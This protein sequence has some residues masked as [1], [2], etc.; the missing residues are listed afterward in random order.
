MSKKSKRKTEMYTSSRKNGVT[1][2]VVE[3]SSGETR[4]T[5]ISTLYP[6]TKLF[7]Y[8]TLNLHRVQQYLWGE[9]MQGKP[10]TLYNFELKAWQSSNI[11]YIERKPGETVVGKVYELDSKQLSATDDYEGEMYERITIKGD[12]VSEDIDVYIKR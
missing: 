4:K 10:I 6:K 2:E 1:S 7:C 3:V 11:F 12:V 5:K 9:S 8:G